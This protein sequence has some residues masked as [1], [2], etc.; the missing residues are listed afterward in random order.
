MMM[1][2]PRAAFGVF[3]LLITVATV[4]V[5]RAMAQTTTLTPT[6]CGAGV[7]AACGTEELKKCD[8]TFSFN[9]NVVM[10]SGGLTWS[11]T[12]CT[13]AGYRTLYKDTKTASTGT[14][15][16]GSCGGSTGTG[17]SGMRGS[18]DDEETLE[19]CEM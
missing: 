4:D 2:I 8:T 13:S 18:G 12:N 10:Q 7:I 17:L 6:A 1:T 16:T 5:S 11:S 14:T 9:L 3:A 19:L 15:T